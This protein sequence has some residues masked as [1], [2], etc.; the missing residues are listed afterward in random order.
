[1]DFKIF[2]ESIASNIATYTDRLKR[3][4]PNH[5]PQFYNTH[6]QKILDIEKKDPNPPDFNDSVFNKYVN[7]LS[8]Q[9]SVDPQFQDKTPYGAAYPTY[10][11]GLKQKHTK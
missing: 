6:I 7:G 9:L 2:I 1:M 11:H 4:F 10:E 8:D 5:Q 3:L